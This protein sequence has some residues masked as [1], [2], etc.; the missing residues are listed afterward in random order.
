MARYNES[1]CRLCRRE[2]LKLFLKGD[3]CYSDKCAFQKRSYAPGQHGNKKVKLSEYGTQL[4]EKQKARRIYGVLEGQFRNYFVMAD[5]KK[6]VT[7]ENLLI[8]LESRLDNV[9]Y[10]LGFGSSRA[11]ARQLVNHSHFTVNGKKV[12]VASYLTKPGDVITFKETS[13]KSDRVK[14]IM[15]VAA[16]KVIPAWLTLDADN[17]SGSVLRMPLREEIDAPIAEHMIVEFYSK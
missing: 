4:R 10:N 8:I 15:E 6:G 7:G 3:R 17:F 16:K 13:R 2:G 12:N 11:E 9:V 1:V 14:E 5:R